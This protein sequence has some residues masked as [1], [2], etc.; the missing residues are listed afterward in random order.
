[1]TVIVS[2]S[3][4]TLQVGIDR[5]GERAG[6]LDALAADGLNPVSVKVTV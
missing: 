3:A 2:S 1:M 5:G 4:P 6:Q